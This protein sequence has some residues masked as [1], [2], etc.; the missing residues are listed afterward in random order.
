MTEEQLRAFVTG[1]QPV[2]Q[3]A[4]IT[5]QSLRVQ[6]LPRLVCCILTATLLWRF[7]AASQQIVIPPELLSQIKWREAA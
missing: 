5:Y 3:M 1:I 7:T 6:R 4:A 2:A